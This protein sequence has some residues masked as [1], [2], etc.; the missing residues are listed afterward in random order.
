MAWIKKGYQIFENSSYHSGFKE[1]LCLSPVTSLKIS[2]CCVIQC[3][4]WKAV[5]LQK[6]GD[7]LI[8]LPKKVYA[9]LMRK[10]E[11]LDRED[12]SA[13]AA[14]FQRLCRPN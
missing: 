6:Y 4:K 3:M 10:R 5:L 8:I 2:I 7:K 14:R 1:K 11:L 9:A 12:S 13:Y